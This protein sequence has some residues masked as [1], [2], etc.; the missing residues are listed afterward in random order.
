[1]DSPCVLSAGSCSAFLNTIVRLSYLPYI[2]PYI[3][4]LKG[5]T[6]LPSYPFEIG[7]RTKLLLLYRVIFF[8]FFWSRDFS[9]CL[10][11]FVFGF[12]RSL[13]KFLGQGSDQSH[14]NDNVESL[15]ARPPGNSLDQGFKNGILWNSVIK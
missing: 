12:P 15:T 9:V 1:M 5:I 10:F 2:K 11:H 8:F 7:T 3:I 13:Q 4:S 6:W 14:S